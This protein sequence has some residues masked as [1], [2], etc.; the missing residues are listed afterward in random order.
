M[1]DGVSANTGVF[2]GGTL[3]QSAGGSL[4]GLGVTGGTN[5]LVSVDVME[6]FRVQTSTYAPEYGRSRGGQISIATRS[7]TNQLHGGAFDYLRNDILTRTT[8]LQTTADWRSQCFDRMTSAAS[9]VVQSLRAKPSSFFCMKGCN[10]ASRK[11]PLQ[12]RRRTL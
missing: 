6:E 1:V 5:S 10:Y 7:G 2:S 9:W 12:P 4:P 11:A 8:G 3:G